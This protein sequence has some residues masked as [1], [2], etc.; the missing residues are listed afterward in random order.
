MGWAHRDSDESSCGA[1]AQEQSYQLPSPQLGL[2]FSLPLTTSL[3]TGVLGRWH[4]LVC[5]PLHVGVLVHSEL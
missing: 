3:K 4:H 5:G 1:L 2:F